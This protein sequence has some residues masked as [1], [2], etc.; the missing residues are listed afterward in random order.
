MLTGIVER[1]LVLHPSIQP[2]Q[3][4]AIGQHLSKSVG[5]FRQGQLMENLI[6][7]GLKRAKSRPS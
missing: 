4:K 3:E 5:K 7:E 2:R 1:D 6:S